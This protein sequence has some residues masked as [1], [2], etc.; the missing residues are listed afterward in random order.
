MGHLA[1]GE[2]AR[3]ALGLERVIFF[4]A[5]DPQMKPRGPMASPEDRAQMT[6]LAIEGNPAFE[7]SRIELDRPGPSYAVDTVDA[8]TREAR[9]AG[10]QVAFTFILSAEAFLGLPRWHQPDRLVEMCR[11]VVVP[12]ADVEPPPPSWL[13][14]H[15]PGRAD[16]FT[17]LDRPHL[18]ISSTEIRAR[19]GVGRSI[20][21]LVPEAVRAYIADHRLYQAE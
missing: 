2:A 11:F 9:A 13:N 14:D 16:R 21:Y 8:L 6:A 20:R 4:P 18:A 1:A 3:E 5:G 19:V 7:L 12:R 15:F 17:M 10:K